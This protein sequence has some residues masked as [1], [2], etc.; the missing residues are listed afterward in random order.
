MVLGRFD[1]ALWLALAAPYEFDRSDAKRE[2][3]TLRDG[4]GQWAE[5]KTAL[6]KGH[7][8]SLVDYL[9]THPA[10]FKGAVSRL[11]PEL[12]GLYLSAFQSYLWNRML[13]AWLVRNVSAGHLTWVDLK[14]GR[15]PA[16]VTWPDE[17]RGHWDN[18]VLPLPSA[19]LKPDPHAP[20]N[21]IV[22]E[23]LKEE[24]LTLPELKIPGLQKPFFSRGE[25]AGYVLPANMESLGENDER[26]RTRRKLTLRFELPRGSYATMLVKRITET[27]HQP[28]A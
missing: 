3:K 11:R 8:R 10:D 26:H 1:R 14:L 18:L 21:A 6:P 28:E 27:N 13:A 22:E 4:W 17:T 23:V 16:P 9:V 2:K 24:G 25:R 15:V 7:A 12:Q 20:W 19:R 5:L